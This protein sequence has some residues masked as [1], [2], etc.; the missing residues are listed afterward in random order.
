MI[1][2]TAKDAVADRVANLDAGA[3]DYVVKPFSFAELLARVRVRRLPQPDQSS[4]VVLA[5]G[6][7]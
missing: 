6:G 7:T 1:V 3:D 2:L 4:P 5:V